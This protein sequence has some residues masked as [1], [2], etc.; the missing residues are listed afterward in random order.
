VPQKQTNKKMPKEALEYI[1]GLEFD[2]DRVK[3]LL[4]DYKR[5]NQILNNHLRSYEEEMSNGTL[6]SKLQEIMSKLKA[7]TFR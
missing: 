6:Q 5:Q 2:L 4:E 3:T 7:L 1:S